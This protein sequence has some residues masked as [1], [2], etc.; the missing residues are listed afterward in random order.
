MQKLIIASLLALSAA[1]NA[2]TYQLCSERGDRFT[3]EAFRDA[4]QTI[5]REGKEIVI[6]WKISAGLFSTATYVSRG[7]SI[8]LA[9]EAFVRTLRKC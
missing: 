2:D 3:V 7:P 4:K 1:A 8:E 5:N 6:T 9:T